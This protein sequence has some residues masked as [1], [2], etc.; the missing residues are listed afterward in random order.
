MLKE[1]TMN[2][3]YDDLAKLEQDRDTKRYEQAHASKLLNQ[4]Y[5]Q[6][7]DEDLE[8]MRRALVEAHRRND[9]GEINKLE[10]N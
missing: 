8:M 9:F 1:T 7:K 5:R 10:R 6:S 2:T 3:R 4:V